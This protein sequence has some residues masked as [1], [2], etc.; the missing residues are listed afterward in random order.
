M[1]ELLGLC[2]N[3]ANFYVDK[4]CQQVADDNGFPFVFHNKQHLHRKLSKDCFGRNWL[5]TP[6][7]AQMCTRHVHHM[8]TWRI[9]YKHIPEPPKWLKFTIEWEV[10]QACLFLS[11]LV[12]RSQWQCSML[13]VTQYFIGTAL[14]ATCFHAGIL[15]SLFFNPE[16]GLHY[17]YFSLHGSNHLPVGLDIKH[18]IYY[19]FMMTTHHSSLV[20]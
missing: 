20:Q 14:L 17:I 4:F 7:L 9:Q 11:V 16:D 2:L 19:K 6:N 5:D 13:K 8:A 10:A 1:M 3:T 15:L 12:N 18:V